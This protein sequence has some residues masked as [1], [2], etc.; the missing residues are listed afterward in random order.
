MRSQEMLNEDSLAIIRL[1]RLI[2]PRIIA[3]KNPTIA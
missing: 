3:F 2:L 1:G